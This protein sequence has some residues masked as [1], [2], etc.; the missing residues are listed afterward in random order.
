LN[1]ADKA[2]SKPSRVLIPLNGTD[3]DTGALRAAAEIVAP[4]AE[5]LLLHVRSG[6]DEE[7]YPG[8]L[9]ILNPAEKLQRRLESER[10]F[11]RANAI[12]ATRGLLSARQLAVQG[13][14]TKMI[15]RYAKRTGAELIVLVVEGLFATIGAR[16]MI[17]HAPCA[18]LVARP[19]R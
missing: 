4:D 10:I 9:T 15:L 16:R 5:I 18:T 3:R 1:Q 7:Q 6:P 11:A 19:L 8:L 14:P 17:D 2:K 12:L 13:K